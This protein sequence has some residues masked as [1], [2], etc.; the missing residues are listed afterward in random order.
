MR[1]VY[2]LAALGGAAAAI[3]PKLEELARRQSALSS[4]SQP[5]PSGYT[6]T[7]VVTSIFPE[8][9][10][11]DASSEES[12]LPIQCLKG[13]FMPAG[14]YFSCYVTSP[15]QN[16]SLSD[17]DRCNQYLCNSTIYDQLFECLNC[18]IANGNERPFGYHTNNSI[19]ATPTG[20]TASISRNPNGL[21]D[22]QQANAV[23]K[24]V[25]DRCQSIG[26]AVTAGGISITA[27]PTTTGP[28]YTTWTKSATVEFP[29]WTGLTRFISDLEVTYTVTVPVST[30]STTNSNGSGSQAASAAASSGSSSS[31]ATTTG[32]DSTFSNTLAGI[33][34]WLALQYVW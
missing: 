16:G 25:T 13:C 22:E 19:T 11:N 26:Q 24:N 12:T 6:T 8:G 1:Y 7:A 29:D 34:C 32:R 18:I 14:T 27:S 3:L 23:L 15:F 5:V 2:L 30:G 10:R 17:P 33:G 28:Y 9:V 20:G 4:S 31:A 21:I